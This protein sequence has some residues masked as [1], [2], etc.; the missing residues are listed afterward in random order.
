MTQRR[1]GHRPWWPG[2][3]YRTLSQEL[4]RYSTMS[5]SPRQ[6]PSLGLAYSTAPGI[7]I[8]LEIMLSSREK[9]CE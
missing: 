5:I 9:I 6:V 4:L 8:R 3:L 2:Y 1:G 7:S